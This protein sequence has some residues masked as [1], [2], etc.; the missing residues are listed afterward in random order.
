MYK[1]Q[2]EEVKAI[3]HRAL[4]GLAGDKSGLRQECYSRRGAKIAKDGEKNLTAKN[5]KYSK[6]EEL[7]MIER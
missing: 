6:D 1:K 7:F 5:A 3:Q 2:L 4:S